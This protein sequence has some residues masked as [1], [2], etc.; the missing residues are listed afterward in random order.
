MIWT[1]KLLWQK[2]K[3]TGTNFAQV[4]QAEEDQQ[5]V[6]RNLDFCQPLGGLLVSHGAPTEEPEATRGNPAVLLPSHLPAAVGEGMSESA[7]YLPPGRL[8]K[9]LGSRD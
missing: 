3:F 4:V 8:G 9:P 6:A 5:T 2:Q 7:L 1:G